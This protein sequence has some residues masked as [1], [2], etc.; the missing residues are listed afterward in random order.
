MSLLNQNRQK[1]RRQNS[2]QLDATHVPFFTLLQKLTYANFIEESSVFHSNMPTNSKLSKRTICDMMRFARVYNDWLFANMTR[3]SNVNLNSGDRSGL[4]D[5]GY[6]GKFESLEFWYKNIVAPAVYLCGS[7]F[8]VWDCSERS[9]LFVC[10]PHLGNILQQPYCLKMKKM[11]KLTWSWVHKGRT[12]CLSWYS[13][14]FRQARPPCMWAPHHVC[15]LPSM[16][17]RPS[18]AS[19]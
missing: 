18:S 15:R 16:H 3:L 13:Y 1:S 19:S 10:E 11:R 17:G 4:W 2:L 7:C 5:F 6:V 12:A 8:A 14:W 9:H